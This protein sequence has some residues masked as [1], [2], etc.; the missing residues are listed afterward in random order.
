MPSN[1]TPKVKLPGNLLYPIVGG[2][3]HLYRNQSG[4]PFEIKATMSNVRR[5][6]GNWTCRSKQH[7]S[8]ASS[9]R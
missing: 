4:A 5:V 7:K 2:A 1:A 6:P 3:F 9:F 8:A